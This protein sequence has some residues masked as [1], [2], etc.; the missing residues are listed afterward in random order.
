MARV[1]VTSA[2]PL[3]T[4]GACWVVVVVIATKEERVMDGWE[5]TFLTAQ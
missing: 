1:L 4:P 2:R 5:G 3:C